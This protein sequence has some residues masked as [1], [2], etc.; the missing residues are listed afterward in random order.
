MSDKSKAALWDF[1]DAY[2]SGMTT[3]SSTTNDAIQSEVAGLASTEYA[4]RT[5]SLMKLIGELR[6]LGCVYLTQYQV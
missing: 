3:P 4:R 5:R 1:D 2:S 6:A